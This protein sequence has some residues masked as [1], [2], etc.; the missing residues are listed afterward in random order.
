MNQGMKQLINHSLTKIIP[1]LNGDLT[2]GQS[3][4]VLLSHGIFGHCYLQCVCE[5]ERFIMQG[6]F[7]PADLP[8]GIHDTSVAC[9]IPSGPL[10]TAYAPA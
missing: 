5:R 4:P 3:S 10:S 2:Q 8:D 6:I 7:C 9:Q 1:F